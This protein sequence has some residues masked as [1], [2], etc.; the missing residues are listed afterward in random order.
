MAVHMGMGENPSSKAIEEAF[1]KVNVKK[2][3]IKLEKPMKCPPG[4][5][6][7][8]VRDLPLLP[9]DAGKQKYASHALDV[10]DHDGDFDM[11]KVDELMGKGK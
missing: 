1:A 2:N 10:L 11:A 3:P 4:E 9:F 6:V 7:Y 8:E 5:K